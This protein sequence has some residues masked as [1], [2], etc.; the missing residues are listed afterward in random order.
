MNLTITGRHMEVTQAIRDHVSEK[1]SRVLRH[2]DHVSQVNVILSVE[3]LQ[4]Q[5]EVTVHVRGKDIVAQVQD[6]NMYAAIDALIH[7]LDRQILKYKERQKDHSHSPL[8]QYPI[9]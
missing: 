3:K 5:A 9:E 6:E 2:F 7:K 8:K 4:H 1:L